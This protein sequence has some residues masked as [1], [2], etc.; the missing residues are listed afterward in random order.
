LNFTKEHAVIR[1]RINS[2]FLP[3]L[4]KDAWEHERTHTHPYQKMITLLTKRIA[5]LSFRSYTVNFSAAFE[6]LFCQMED[7]TEPLNKLFVNDLPWGIV[8][9]IAVILS[10]V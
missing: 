5:T 1:K 3:I 8:Y 9:Q 10:T 7:G 4:E 6:V 2:I